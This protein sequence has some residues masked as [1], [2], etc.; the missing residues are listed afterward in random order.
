[1]ALCSVASKSSKLQNTAL[2]F[3]TPSLSADDENKQTITNRGCS[4]TSCDRPLAEKCQKRG[5]W[6]SGWNK[7]WLLDVNHWT[8]EPSAPKSSSPKLVLIVAEDSA[9]DAQR[10]RALRAWLIAEGKFVQLSP[11][12]SEP[13]VMANMFYGLTFNDAVDSLPALELDDKRTHRVK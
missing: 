4:R 12:D 9:A 8:E 10:Y 3:G 5:L 13:F 2:Q 6:L 7:K 1:M 11:E